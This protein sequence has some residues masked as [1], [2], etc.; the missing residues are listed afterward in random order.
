MRGCAL[1]DWASLLARVLV[2]EEWGLVA[3]LGQW[4]TGCVVEDMWEGVA[5]IAYLESSP[6]CRGQ[7]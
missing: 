1:V 4:S 6:D 7:D 2:L 3:G 5:H